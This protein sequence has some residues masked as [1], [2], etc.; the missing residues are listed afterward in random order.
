MFSSERQAFLNPSPALSPLLG[1]TLVTFHTTSSALCDVM[2][3]ELKTDSI[4][5]AESEYGR[6]I[7]VMAATIMLASQYEWQP[8]AA[9]FWSGA[10]DGYIKE[11]QETIER[12]LWLN[13]KTI[14]VL[15][16]IKYL[17]KYLR[18]VEHDSG[19]A[20][21]ARF[22]EDRRQSRLDSD[23]ERERSPGPKASEYTA[24]ELTIGY[25]EIQRRDNKDFVPEKPPAA[26]PAEKEAEVRRFLDMI[27]PETITLVTLKRELSAVER[28][29]DE[30]ESLAELAE[31]S[32]RIDQ[33]LSNS[34]FLQFQVLP[35]GGGAADQKLACSSFVDLL[36]CWSEL[37]S[38][39]KQRIALGETVCKLIKPL[40]DAGH[41]YMIARK[42]HEDRQRIASGTK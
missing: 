12:S 41:D 34:D 16:C 27:P 33:A 18:A 5:K 6:L 8:L 26:C 1:E 38:G 2:D 7:G 40:S 31:V 30:H 3:M 4:S 29:I 25:E 35:A 10:R 13:A 37:I 14:S 39:A 20:A 36:G 9:D 28:A 21:G 15:N 11:C 42:A 23:R 22:R 19:Y 32:R 24:F 17:R